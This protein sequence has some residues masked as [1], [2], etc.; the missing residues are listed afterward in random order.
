M[1]EVTNRTFLLTDHPGIGK[2]T[3]IQ[4]VLH[5]VLYTKGGSF[6]QEI[7]EGG[8]RLGFSIVTLDGQQEVFAHDKFPK[9]YHIGKYDVDLDVLNSIGVVNIRKAMEGNDLV[10]IDEYRC[11]GIARR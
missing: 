11:N 5:K 9:K 10:V 1:A 4:Q 2:T 7:K 8:K 3:I 6:K